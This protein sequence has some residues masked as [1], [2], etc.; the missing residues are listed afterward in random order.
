MRQPTIYVPHGGGP[1]PWIND[2]GGPGAMAPLRQFLADLPGT[3][4]EP[5]RAI[6]CVTAHWEEDVV[7][8]STAARPGMLYDYGGFPAHT[9]Q[10]TWPAPGAPQVAARVQTMLEGAGIKSGVN[11]ARGYDH[12]TFVP[13]A[14]AWP[15]AEVPTVQMSLVRGLDPATHDNIGRAL[16]PLRDEGVLIVGSGMSYHSMRGYGT[17]QGARDA[18]IFDSWLSHSVQDPDHRS[19]ALS[20][21]ADAPAGRSSHPREEHLLP[22]MVVTGAA[23]RDVASLP[24][25][26]PV[27]GTRVSA[28]RY[29]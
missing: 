25:Q 9:Y 27:L 22:L 12:G 15:G 19:A 14:V 23:G 5:P 21:W 4:P 18:A 16:Q 28:V 8:V 6:L 13:L 29:G 3:L 11:A 2:F 26:A 10:I 24:F 7:T 20:K 1:W 17:E